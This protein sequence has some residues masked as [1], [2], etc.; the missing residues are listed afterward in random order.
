MQA[1]IYARHPHLSAGCQRSS[2]RSHVLH[3]GENRSASGCGFGSGF[4]SGSRS[5]SGSGFCSALAFD[6]SFRSVIL[7]L[8]VAL[9]L[10][11]LVSGGVRGSLIDPTVGSV[12]LCL[13]GEV[14]A[15][16]YTCLDP[17]TP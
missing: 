12:Q 6:L 11:P 9:T 4:A 2:L 7:A 17:S 15:G 1:M 10:S 14:L 8:A 16:L 13:V 5:G 3:S